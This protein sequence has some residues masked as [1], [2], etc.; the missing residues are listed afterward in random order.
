L[1]YGLRQ[2]KQV[3]SSEENGCEL[4]FLTTIIEN[5]STIP[6]ILTNGNDSV[7]SWKNY[8]SLSVSEKGYLEG[9]LKKT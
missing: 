1:K 4:G 9:R 3:I 7:L 2:F 6:V 8:D 5:N